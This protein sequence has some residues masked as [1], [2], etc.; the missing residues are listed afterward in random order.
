MTGAILLF[1]VSSR[2]PYKGINYLAGLCP[3]VFYVMSP[4]NTGTEKN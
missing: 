3:A 2:G 1:L 4:S